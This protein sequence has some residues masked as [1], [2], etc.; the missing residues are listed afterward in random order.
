MGEEDEGELARRQAERDA[1]YAEVLKLFH[2]PGRKEGLAR[3]R[4]KM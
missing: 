1:G 2:T 3:L 4:S